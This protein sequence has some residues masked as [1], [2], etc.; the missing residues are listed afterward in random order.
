MWT[1]LFRNEWLGFDPIWTIRVRAT[2]RWTYRMLYRILFLLCLSFYTSYLAGN[3][4]E[5]GYW[6]HRDFTWVQW[7]AEWIFIPQWQINVRFRLHSFRLI[8]WSTYH[9]T[10]LISSR[11]LQRYSCVQRTWHFNSLFLYSSMFETASGFVAWCFRISDYDHTLLPRNSMLW[12][13]GT[14]HRKKT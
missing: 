3:L 10:A 8:F 13:I 12:S 6:C 2:S 5:N 14:F 1:K 9:I 11:I 4:L 7:S